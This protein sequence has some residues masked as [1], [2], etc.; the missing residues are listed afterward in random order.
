M[1]DLGLSPHME[2]KWHSST[3]EKP[4]EKMDT[5]TACFVNVKKMS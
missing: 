4:A 1:Y 2:E 3:A 5:K